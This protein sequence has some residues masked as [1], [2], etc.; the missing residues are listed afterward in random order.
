MF[1]L[2]DS[3]RAE[4]PHPAGVQ[5]SAGEEISQGE[6]P[7]SAPPRDLA[8]GHSARFSVTLRKI[9]STRRQFQSPII[10]SGGCPN[11]PCRGHRVLLESC[12][13]LRCC[14]CSDVPGRS[15][16]RATPQSDE[17][18]RHPSDAPAPGIG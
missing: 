12:R 17:R 13:R 14:S 18:P 1:V 6:G 8:A 10:L 3:V 11:E 9:G 7:G 5:A 15:P 2:W 16:V 4:L